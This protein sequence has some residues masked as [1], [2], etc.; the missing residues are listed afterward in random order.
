MNIALSDN[1][2]SKNELLDSVTATKPSARLERLREHYLKLE[3]IA[4]IDRER[5]EVESMR[6]TEGEPMVLRKAKAFAAIVRQRPI[7]IFE[8]ELIV[9]W[10]D[11]SPFS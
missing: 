2:A 8:D 1:L 10:F 7:D 9:G 5:I 4:T 6:A 3:W 11:F